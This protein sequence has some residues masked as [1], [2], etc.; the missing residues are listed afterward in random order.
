MVSPNR[1]YGCGVCLCVC[2]C[3]CL[4][5]FVCSQFGMLLLR[6]SLFFYWTNRKEISN[7]FNTNVINNITRTHLFRGRGMSHFLIMLNTRSH[8]MFLRYTVE[9]GLFSFGGICTREPHTGN[10][11]LPVSFFTLFLSTA[12]MEICNTKT[13]NDITLHYQA[14]CLLFKQ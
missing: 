9:I 12:N 2:V 8:N 7:M 10:R 4:C 13:G 6:M 5:A 11:P 1:Y 3:V 14:A